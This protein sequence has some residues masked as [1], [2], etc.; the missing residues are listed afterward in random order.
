MNIVQ[1]KVRGRPPKR[2]ID[3][4]ADRRALVD[5]AVAILDAG[6]AAALTARSVAERAKAA[7]ES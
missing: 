2:Q 5:A 6:G 7:I 4:A 1:K 3:R